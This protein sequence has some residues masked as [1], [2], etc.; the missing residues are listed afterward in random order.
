MSYA[1]NAE[2]GKTAEEAF[3][4]LR[5]RIVAVI[6]ASQSGDYAKLDSIILPSVLKW[7][8]AFLYQS[9]DKPGIVGCAAG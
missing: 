7:K 1:W 2:L 3:A 4:M 8:T 9:P 6:E 5:S